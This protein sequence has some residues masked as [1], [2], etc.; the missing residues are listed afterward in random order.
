MLDGAV[1]GMVYAFKFVRAM[2]FWVALYVMEK[3]YQDAYVQAVLVEGKPPP[4]LWGIVATAVAVEFGAMLV[5]AAVL[6][7]VQSK[8]KAASNTFVLDD[9]L[10]AALAKD[11]AVG[12]VAILAVGTLLARAAENGQL[13]RYRDDGLR[14]IRALCNMVLYV[15][16]V[17]FAIPFYAL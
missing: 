15:S 4:D 10:M 3:V 11:Y 17:V 13:F 6:L 5:L 1:H 8:Y 14:G 12:S 7:L 16:F 2:V 9:G